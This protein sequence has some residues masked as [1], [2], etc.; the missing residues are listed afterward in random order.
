[1]RHSLHGAKVLVVVLIMAVAGIAHGVPEDI[2][3]AKTYFAAGAQAYSVGQYTAAIQ[4]FDE[5]Y[6][7]APRSAI[8]FSTAQALR[9]QYFVDRN[10]T[11]LDRAIDLYRRYVDEVPQGGR[12]NDAVQALSEL[13]PVAARLDLAAEVGPGEPRSRALPG[14]RLMVSSPTNGA[15]ISVDGSPPLPA[16]FIAEV[17]PGTHRVRVTAPGYYHDEREVVTVKGGLLAFDVRLRERPGRLRV[18]VEDGARIYVDGRNQG[19]A[20][21]SGAMEFSAGKHMVSVVRPGY[22][23]ISQEV[24]LEKGKTKTVFVELQPSKQRNVSLV[25]LGAGGVSL[26]VS[27][28]FFGQAFERQQAAEEV[29][30]RKS[31]GNITSEDLD[32]YDAA[33]RDRDQLRRAGKVALSTSLALGAVGGLLYFFDTPQV[34]TASTVD[35]PAEKKT[36]PTEPGTL[37]AVPVVSPGLVGVVGTF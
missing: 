4:A 1:M 5:A 15:R 37:S 6:R 22:D 14:T 25:M 3:K 7:L 10:R 9:R 33:R 11:H 2:E 26:V 27:A 19:E 35:K 12:R 28:G 23:G 16:P 29:L 34:P 8:L 30:D 31:E 18:L 21:L 24:L 13:E 32:V 20:P 36:G 17:D